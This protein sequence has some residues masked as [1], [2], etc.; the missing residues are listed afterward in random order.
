MAV[1][2][3][4]TETYGNRFLEP[5]SRSA[6]LFARARQLL[7]GGNTRTNGSFS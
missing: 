1:P 5:G 3:T 6:A 7:P 2:T 4:P